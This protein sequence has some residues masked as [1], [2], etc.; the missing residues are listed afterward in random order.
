MKFF[1]IGIKDI[2][3]LV[4]I[5]I[6]L[7]QTCSKPI[8]PT[9]IT[10]V[11]GKK[12]EVIKTIID[13]EYVPEYRTKWKKGDS[14]PF[15]VIV[16]DTV[17]A[18]VDTLSILRDYYLTKVYTDTFKVAYG[19]FRIKDTIARNRVIGRSYEADLLVPIQKEYTVVKELP[20]T[21][22]Y[23]GFNAVFNR[24][25]GLGSFGPKVL[26][27]SKKDHLYWVGAGLGLQ[28]NPQVGLGM[29]WKVK[30]K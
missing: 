19:Q 21:Q 23:I 5:L 13:T 1:K 27:K 6:V 11:D 28:S 2:A 7:F 10:K 25:D 18:V 14:I 4:L 20:K 12:Y 3:V 24:V 17:P 9:K 26:L 22:L 16:H 30:F 15:E 8:N 29:A